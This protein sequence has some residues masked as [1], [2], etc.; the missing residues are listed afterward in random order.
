MISGGKVPHKLHGRT[1]WPASK[2]MLPKARSRVLCCLLPKAQFKSECI[3]TTGYTHIRY[4]TSY[5]LLEVAAVE[6]GALPYLTVLPTPGMH[7]R[8]AWKG[9]LA[10]CCQSRL[11]AQSR[12]WQLSS[13]APSSQHSSGQ[14]S[15]VSFSR[16]AEDGKAQLIQ[17]S[18]FSFDFREC[19]DNITEDRKNAVQ[20][21]CHT[22]TRQ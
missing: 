5:T 8:A 6:N 14:T 18:S 15:Q 3:R 12:W 13:A 17:L 21:L 16:V 1:T 10:P 7:L 20:Q 4:A 9:K 2:Q 22:C 19:S 11:C